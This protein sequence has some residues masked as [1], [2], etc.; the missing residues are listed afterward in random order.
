ML[1]I[2]VLS[3]LLTT[4]LSHVCTFKVQPLRVLLV[5]EMK[6]DKEENNYWINND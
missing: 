2:R 4:W 1:I 6:I 5:N 3:L